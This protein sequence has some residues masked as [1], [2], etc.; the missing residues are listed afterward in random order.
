M[1]FNYQLFPKPKQM[2]IINDDEIR[3]IDG[4]PTAISRAP[5]LSSSDYQLSELLQQLGRDEAAILARPVKLL[6]DFKPAAM[7]A[8]LRE[9][10]EQC[11]GPAG[12]VLIRKDRMPEMLW[13]YDSANGVNRLV[14]CRMS[15]GFVIGRLAFSPN[16]SVSWYPES[17]EERELHELILS[18]LARAYM[19][20]QK[21][22][23]AEE[24][25]S[26]ADEPFGPE[27]MLDEY[28]QWSDKHPINL[29]DEIV[30]PS[31]NTEN[32]Q[33]EKVTQHAR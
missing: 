29:H 32:G 24:L 18:T 19:N 22:I 15:G 6:G 30:I 11:G 17:G 31:V 21:W 1:N 28:S 14:N 23:A 3:S 16:G 4:S 13:S 2:D 20:D 7:I 12:I 5:F 25:L 33:A 26:L 27:M 10:A 8:K 9:T